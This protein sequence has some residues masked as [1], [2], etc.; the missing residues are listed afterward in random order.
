[1][2]APR[3]INSFDPALRGMTKSNRAADLLNNQ[4]VFGF[5]NN[6][7]PNPVINSL[8][9]TKTSR[10]EDATTDPMNTAVL[11]TNTSGLRGVM[12]CKGA[13][14]GGVVPMGM[15]GVLRRPA[16]TDKDYMYPTPIPG[17]RHMKKGL[18][19]QPYYCPPRPLLVPAD[20]FNA[21]L[22]SRLGV[23]S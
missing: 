23:P 9:Y 8:S 1:M 6:D 19:E 3:E 15:G 11:N 2:F 14:S 16:Q 22:Q 7:I 13:A 21:G 4:P 18:L 17:L 5:E 10:L 20:N 12:P